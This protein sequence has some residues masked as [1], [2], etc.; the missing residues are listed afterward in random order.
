MD[1]K[2]LTKPIT[3]IEIKERIAS[4]QPVLNLRNIVGYAAARNMRVLSDALTEY[5][6][7]ERE[8]I[9]KYGVDDLDVN[10]KPTGTKSISP[11]SENFDSFIKEMSPLQ[12]IVQE[13]PIMIVKFKE[14]I[15]FL[16]GK[17]ILNIDWMLED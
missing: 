5:T 6:Q 1:T 4:L 16:S 14:V 11:D 8:A 3:N 10:G 12:R 7:F 2:I 17:E 13:V 9:L 15:G